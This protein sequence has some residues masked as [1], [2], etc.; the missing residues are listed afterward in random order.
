MFYSLSLLLIVFTVVFIFFLG[1][2]FR[3]C[4]EIS[5]WWLLETI[6]WNKMAMPKGTKKA[7]HAHQLFIYVYNISSCLLFTS[8]HHTH[9]P[10]SPPPEANTI[11]FSYF[12]IYVDAFFFCFCNFYGFS[13]EKFLEGHQIPR[14]SIEICYIKLYL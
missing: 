7:A 5:S 9:P 10:P 4:G 13:G 11:L 6:Q 14:I 3:L 8:N 12:Y 1:R 2:V